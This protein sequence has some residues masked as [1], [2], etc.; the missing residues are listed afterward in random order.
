ML[1]FEIIY[2]FAKNWQKSI[3]SL[4]NIYNTSCCVKQMDNTI[5]SVS[6]QENN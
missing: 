1:Y 3:F 6:I 2:I 5:T 4:Y